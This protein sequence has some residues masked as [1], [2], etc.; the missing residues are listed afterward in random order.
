MKSRATSRFWKCYAKLPQSV[1]QQA[2]KAYQLWI[3]DS[4][5]PGLHFKQIG[6]EEPIYAV[7]VSDV[8]RALGVLENDVMLWFWIDEYER[9]LRR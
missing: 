9:L 6:E 8:Y 2:R 7:R 5:H 4:R 1:R 3:E